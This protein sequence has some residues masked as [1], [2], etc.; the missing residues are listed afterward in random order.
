MAIQTSY[1]LEPVET[2]NLPQRFLDAFAAILA[3]SN[4]APVLAATASVTT[5]CGRCTLTCPVYQASGEARDIP[6]FRSELVLGIY[7]R[8]FTPAGARSTRPTSTPWPRSSTAA[9][10]AAAARA[11]APWASTTG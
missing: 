3:H 9:P 11:S 8:Y 2:Q 10:P 7:R 5:R 1:Y 4:Y 6:C